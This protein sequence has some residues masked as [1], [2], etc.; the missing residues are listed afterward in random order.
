MS[1]KGKEININNNINNNIIINNNDLNN[2]NNN[3][4]SQPLNSM[5]RDNNNNFQGVNPMNYIM[6]SKR[7]SH[8]VQSKMTRPFITPQ[9]DITKRPSFN[10]N[11][12]NHFQ[13]SYTNTDISYKSI[14]NKNQ[15]KN[16]NALKTYHADIWP[17]SSL[18]H[19]PSGWAL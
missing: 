1:N 11:N 9:I 19:K 5:M 8:Q 3:L 17:Q 15:I 7:P 2:N 18:P 4:Y 13:N 12:P 10:N 16:P 6:I 14:P